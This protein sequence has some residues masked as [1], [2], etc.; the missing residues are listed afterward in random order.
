MGLKPDAVL[1]RS[2][3]AIEDP[4]CSGKAQHQLLDIPVIALCATID[5]A[6]SW[7]EIAQYERARDLSGAAERRCIA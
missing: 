6:E 5:G 2:F 1:A 4:R 7:D 3:G